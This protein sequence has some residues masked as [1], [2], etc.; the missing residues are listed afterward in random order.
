MVIPFLMDSFQPCGAAC[1]QIH[2]NHWEAGS[3]RALSLLSP[4]GFPLVQH[5]LGDCE[6]QAINSSPSETVEC[7]AVHGYCWIALLDV[8]V[9]LSLAWYLSQVTPRQWGAEPR[10][11][12]FPIEDLLACFSGSAARSAT[13]LDVH[14]PPPPPPSDRPSPCLEPLIHMYTLNE[15]E[16]EC[17]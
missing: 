7:S 10:P 2:K 16:S 17:A 5:Q 14:S 1:A 9:Y 4:A 11:L 8:G 12:S 6:L 3:L 15:T 13:L